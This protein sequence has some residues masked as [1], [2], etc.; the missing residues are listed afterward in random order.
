MSSFTREEFEVFWC[1]HEFINFLLEIY[2]D[3]DNDAN[4]FAA[5]IARLPHF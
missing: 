3:E 2:S 5:R 4:V 1:N